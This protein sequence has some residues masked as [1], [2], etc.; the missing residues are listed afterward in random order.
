MVTEGDRVWIWSEV[1]EADIFIISGGN[2]GRIEVIVIEGQQR[3][4]G[5]GRGIFNGG[6]GTLERLESVVAEGGDDGSVDPEV[7]GV[8]LLRQLGLE[9]DSGLSA[10]RRHFEEGEKAYE[11]MRTRRRD[12]RR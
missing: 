5:G 10:Q 1:H 12:W 6:N 8:E 9:E 11:E 3:V 4:V 2:G 7:L